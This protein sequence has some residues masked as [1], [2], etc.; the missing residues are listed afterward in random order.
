MVNQVL[1]LHRLLIVSAQ[2]I[3]SVTYTF[4]SYDKFFKSKHHTLITFITFFNIQKCKAGDKREGNPAMSITGSYNVNT[5]STDVQSEVKRLNA[6][7]DLFWTK[8]IALFMHWGMKDDLRIADLGCGTGYLIEKLLHQF[9]SS[10]FVGVEQDAHLV[11]LARDRL[12]QHKSVEEIFEGPINQFNKN[13]SGFDKVGRLS[14]PTP[15]FLVAETQ[16]RYL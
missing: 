14:E 10:K 4:V 3:E 16:R 5:F 1:N 15:G 12:C 7:I 2:V 6:Q 13:N 11:M 8:E 9:P